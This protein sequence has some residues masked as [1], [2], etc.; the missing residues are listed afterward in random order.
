MIYVSQFPSS[1][2]LELN[3]LHR[4]GIV[5]SI[6]KSSTKISFEIIQDKACINIMSPATILRKAKTAAGL[7][8]L[9]LVWF[10]PVWV[11]LGLSRAAILTI[12]FRR[13]AKHLGVHDGL[14]PRTPLVSDEQQKRGAIL[15]KTIRLAALYTPWTSNCFPQAIT[16]R[17]L[18]GLYGIPYALFFGLRKSEE[19]GDLEAHAWVVSGPNNVTGGSGFRHH[20]SVGCFV[21]EGY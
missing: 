7:P 2:E 9:Q 4:I 17:I 15:G 16:A 18:L 11:L 1:I 10:A 21:T 14:A 19:T 12:T 20:T 13:I 6:A 3:S 5:P 8:L